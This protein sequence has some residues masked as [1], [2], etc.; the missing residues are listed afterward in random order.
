MHW[1]V[2]KLIKLFPQKKNKVQKVAYI[3]TIALTIFLALGVLIL[4]IIFLL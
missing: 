1:I 3:A 4:Q 2:G